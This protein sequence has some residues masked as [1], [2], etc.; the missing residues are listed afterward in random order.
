MNRIFEWH[1]ASTFIKD[2]NVMAFK[3]RGIQKGIS[4]VMN[5]SAFEDTLNFGVGSFKKKSEPISR[6]GTRKYVSI[7]LALGS[8]D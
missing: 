7:F 4:Y 6:I 8:D 5:K 3:A 2:K 1:I